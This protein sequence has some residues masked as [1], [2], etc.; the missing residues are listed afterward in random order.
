MAGDGDPELL[1]T[2]SLA[3]Y[4]GGEAAKTVENEKRAIA[5]LPPGKSELRVRMESS[6]AE[7]ERGGGGSK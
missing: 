3:Y 2:L 7:Y 1:D 6:L 5:I 4:R